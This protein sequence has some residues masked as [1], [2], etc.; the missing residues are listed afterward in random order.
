MCLNKP[1]GIRQW[2]V[3]FS[4]CLSYGNLQYLGGVALWEKV[5]SFGRKLFFDVLCLNSDQYERSSLLNTFC[6]NLVKD[7]GNSSSLKTW[8]AVILKQKLCL[9]NLE[10]IKFAFFFFFNK[11]FI[12]HLPTPYQFEKY[13]LT[14]KFAHTFASTKLQNVKLKSNREPV[15]AIKFLNF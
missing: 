9:A 15:T 10:Y 3:V 4:K 8:L 13:Y 5:W 2:N 11:Y 12:S 14:N 6:Y 1:L 7:V